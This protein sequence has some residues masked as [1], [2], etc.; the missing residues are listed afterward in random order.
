MTDIKLKMGVDLCRM[1]LKY[2]ERRID[3]TELNGTII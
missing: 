1:V 2:M 3:K